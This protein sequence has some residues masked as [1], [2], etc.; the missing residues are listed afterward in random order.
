MNAFIQLAKKAAGDKEKPDIDALAQKNKSP[1][2]VLIQNSVMIV[3]KYL[4][5]ILLRCQI[6][7]PLCLVIVL[8]LSPLVAT[9][10]HFRR[11]KIL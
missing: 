2:I 7:A 9:I 1:E 10:D 4:K 3:W 11:E 6:L 8:V 5:H